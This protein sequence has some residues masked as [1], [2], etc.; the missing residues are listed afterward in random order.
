V[1]GRAGSFGLTATAGET[2]FVRRSAPIDDVLY[3]L[4]RRQV[5][6]A[7]ALDE[8]GGTAGLLFLLLA[9]KS[10]HEE[11]WLFAIHP[12]WGYQQR[13]RRLVPWSY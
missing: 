2:V 5:Q 12:E 11:V 9:A 4:Q 7:V 13:M 1:T 6:L 3:E 10:R 8:H